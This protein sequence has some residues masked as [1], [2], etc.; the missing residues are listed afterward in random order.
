M[1]LIYTCNTISTAKAD[2]SAARIFC[3]LP[4][5]FFRWSIIH[6]IAGAWNVSV[7]IFV[8][9]AHIQNRKRLENSSD[10]ET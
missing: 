4:F 7:V 3:S 5:L 6:S 10:L 9:R 8:A 2:L 1:H